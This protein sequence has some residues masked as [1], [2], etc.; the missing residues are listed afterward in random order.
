MNNGF[1]CETTAWGDRVVSPYLLRPLRS[2]E[3]VLKTTRGR[4]PMHEPLPRAQVSTRPPETAAA[5]L[6]RQGRLIQPRVVWVNDAQGP[7]PNP[8]RG[9]RRGPKKDD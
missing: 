2:L 7:A 8:A 9:R 3:E 5:I 4:M 1:M 6:R